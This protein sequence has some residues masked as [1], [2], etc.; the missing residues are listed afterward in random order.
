MVE[1]AESYVLRVL[2][3]RPK[4]R[5]NAGGAA[6]TMTAKK[7]SAPLMWRIREIRGNRGVLLGTIDA[8]ASDTAIKSAIYNKIGT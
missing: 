2:F 7:T 6:T 5:Y 4:P 1:F 8:P 3:A